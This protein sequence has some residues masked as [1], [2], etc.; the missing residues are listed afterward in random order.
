MDPYY[1]NYD[2][3][4]S[5][6]NPRIAKSYMPELNSEPSSRVRNFKNMD[7]TLGGEIF[8]Y[9]NFTPYLNFTKA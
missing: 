4:R 9:P 3:Q 1:D 5:G 7:T 6:N 8:R 2:N